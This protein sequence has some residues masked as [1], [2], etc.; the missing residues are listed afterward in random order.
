MTERTRAVELPERTVARVE[1]RLAGTEFDGTEEYV[2][3]VLREVLQGTEPADDA[4]GVDE[5]Q[6]KDRLES[7]GYLER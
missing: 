1:E 7:L 3:F 4:A 6:V 2:D 5:Q